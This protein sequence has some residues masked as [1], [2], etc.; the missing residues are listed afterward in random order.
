MRDHYDAIV[1]MGRPASLDFRRERDRSRRRFSIVSALTIVFIATPAFADGIDVGAILTGVD[2]ELPVS[3]MIRLIC[4]LMLLNYALNFVVIGI[5]AVRVGPTS[6]RR[7]SLDLIWLTLLA[8]V[9]DRAGSLLALGAGF[10]ALIPISFII[11]TGGLGTL[12]LVFLL[13]DL[14]F[15]GYFVWVL[16]L[17]FLRKRWKASDRAARR[18]SAAAAVLTNP[19]WVIAFGPY[20]TK[21]MTP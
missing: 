16:S 15:S 4:L 5:P 17:H 8:Q 1:L 12:L 14:L 11:Q 20:L 19:V 9:A 18:I 6:F 13:F 21:M 2:S 7:I 10:L 3:A